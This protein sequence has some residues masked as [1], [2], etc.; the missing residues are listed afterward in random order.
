MIEIGCGWY[1]EK[2]TKG[3]P[4]LRIPKPSKKAQQKDDE[5]KIIYMN[6]V[7]IEMIGDSNYVGTSLSGSIQEV[8][9]K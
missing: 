6:L 1:M 9:S 4:P 8:N 7:G 3:L 5:I 2:I